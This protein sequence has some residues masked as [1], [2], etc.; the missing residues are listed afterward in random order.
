MSRTTRQRG[1]ASGRQRL[2]LSRYVAA[3][4]GVPLGGEGSLQNMLRRSLGAGSFAGFWRFWN[5]IWGYY[6]GLYV[7][8]PANRALPYPLAIVVT[9]LVSG[10]I[11]DLVTT[12]VRGSP[13]LLFTPWFF[14]MSVGLLLGETAHMD[15]SAR[16]WAFRVVTNLTYIGTCLLLALRLRV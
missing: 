1:W 4:N 10:A 13:T 11:H 15:L 6:L 9:F 14:L 5:P 3:R 8:R 7:F 16:P 12:A 2:T